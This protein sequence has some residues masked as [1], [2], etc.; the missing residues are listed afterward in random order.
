VTGLE[1]S[2]G[3]MDHAVRKC[4]ALAPPLFD[5]SLS[6]AESSIRGK[7]EQDVPFDADACHRGDRREQLL[8]FVGK[9]AT[10]TSL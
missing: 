5:Q 7:G 6:R 1:A 10:P 4:D 8:R 3:P 9:T 2:F